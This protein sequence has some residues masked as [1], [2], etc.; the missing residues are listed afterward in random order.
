MA[1][2]PRRPRRSASLGQR[3]QAWFATPGNLPWLWIVGTAFVYAIAGLMLASFPAPYWIWNLALAGVL[4]Q[5]IALAGPRALSRFRWW[6]ANLLA[7]LAIVGAGAMV[8]ALAIALN[9][10]GTDQL[11]QLV[12]QQ[13]AMEV[14]KMSL[15][16]VVTAALAGIINA[17]TGDRLLALFNRLQSSLI[18][19]AAG[20]L[21]LAIGGGIGVIAV[22]GAV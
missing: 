1:S 14:L 6:S 20:I 15:I 2:T 13:A 9:Y 22:A 3:F 18:L 4:A 11:D 7:L 21:G 17:E 19:A 10:V 5:A 12:P 16:A 8:V